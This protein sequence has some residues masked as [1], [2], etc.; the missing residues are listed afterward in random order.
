MPAPARTTA[1]HYPPGEGLPHARAHATLH[2]HLAVSIHIHQD[3]FPLG[4]WLVQQR[5]KARSGQLSART[6]HELT[7]L[8]PWWNPPWP[9]IWQRAYHRARASHA[10]GQPIPPELRRWVRKQTT[11]WHQL[12]PHQQ[13]L[14]DNMGVVGRS[15]ISSENRPFE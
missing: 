3:G 8:D 6:L 9:F 13:A 15:R 12:H 5:R 7:V 14:L 11:L 10:T 4:R 2:G 1:R